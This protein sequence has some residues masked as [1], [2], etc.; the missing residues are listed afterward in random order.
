MTSKAFTITTQVNVDG[1]DEGRT[2][3]HALIDALFDAAGAAPIEAVGAATQPHSKAGGAIKD[4][5]LELSPEKLS[6]VLTAL[7]TGAEGAPLNEGER[8]M[9]E[10]IAKCAPAALPYD[11]NRQLLGSGAKFGNVSSGLARRF[12]SR[13]FELPYAPDDANTGYCMQS[14][15]AAVV[16]DVLAATGN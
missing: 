9:L 14:A 1:T 5:R 7:A 13:G 15:V 3:A 10:G 16:L 2:Q 4:G 6:G 11:D 8:T 12:W